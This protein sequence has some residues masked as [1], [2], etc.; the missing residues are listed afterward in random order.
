MHRGLRNVYDLD[1]IKAGFNFLFSITLKR[2]VIHNDFKNTHGLNSIK[3]YLKFL[4]Y[5]V[6]KYGELMLM[7]NEKVISL[8]YVNVFP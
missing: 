4:L 6:L 1:C 7:V 3:S 8:S 2:S 5:L